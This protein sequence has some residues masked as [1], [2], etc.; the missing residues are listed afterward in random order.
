MGQTTLI[1][2]TVT[3]G[4]LLLMFLGFE[5]WWLLRYRRTYLFRVG[6]HDLVVQIT[7]QSVALF[8]DGL[9]QD[10]FAARNMRIVTLRTSVDGGEFRARVESRGLKPSVTATYLGKAVECIGETKR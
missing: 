7:A 1:A 9:I 3:F 5:V 6:G 4:V 2:L 8:M 10:E